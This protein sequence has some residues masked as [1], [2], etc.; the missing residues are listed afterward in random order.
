[1]VWRAMAF[2]YHESCGRCTPCREGTDWMVKILA[3]I[4]NGEGRMDDLKILEDVCHS[5]HNNCFCPLGEGAVM[6][7]LSSLKYFMGE[8]EE[9][10]MRRKCPKGLRARA[11]H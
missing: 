7:V 2:F 9:H 11:R 10:I 3:R 5:I 6:P 8:Y 1:M 4:E